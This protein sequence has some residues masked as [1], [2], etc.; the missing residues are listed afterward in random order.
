MSPSTVLE[1]P[2]VAE[3]INL[4]AY[5]RACAELA[6]A[7]KPPLATP[8][9]TIVVQP[10]GKT[11]TSISAAIA[12]TIANEQLQA[13]LYVG[14]GTYNE[15]VILKPFMH[16]QGSGAD[17]TTITYPA[18]TD[19]YHK[20]TVVAASNSSITSCNIVSSGT[21][22]AQFTVAL[23]CP[24]AAPFSVSNCTITGTD[25]G[26]SQIN[27]YCIT[28]GWPT[29]GHS[30]VY[31][32]YCIVKAISKALNTNPIALI[33]YGDGYTELMTCKV[34]TPAS[35]SGIGWAIASGSNA[36]IQVIDSYV[37]AA[38][39]ALFINEPPATLKAVNCQI[40]GPIGP[41]VIVEK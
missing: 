25:N 17:Q 18:L 27:V 3:K 16:I 7:L 34:I 36:N 14:P 35:P 29:P 15:R 28:N 1:P 31:L 40:N 37:E 6:K 23:D 10:G 9:N 4:A 30:Q 26:N 22:K 41:G 2:K 12:D 11:Y 21:S 13:M 8:A 24:A 32:N 19:P 33:G 39:W 20:G 38:T 5:A